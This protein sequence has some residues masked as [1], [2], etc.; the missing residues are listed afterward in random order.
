MGAR[1][2][3]LR[4][5]VA[6]VYEQV[7]T[8]RAVLDQLDLLVKLRDLLRGRPDVRQQ[9]QRLFDHV[10]LDEFQDTDPLQVE[11]VFFLCED[12]AKAD[13]WRRVRLRPGSLTVV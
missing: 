2:A 12:G 11:A 5:V 13:E 9:L 7:K 10:F 4:F 6:E 1:L 8:E 3:R